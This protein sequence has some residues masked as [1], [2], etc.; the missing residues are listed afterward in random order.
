ML[1]S[2]FYLDSIFDDFMDGKENF[3]MKVDIYEKEN[4]YHIISDIPGVKKEDIKIDFSEGYLTIAF[5]KKEE[6]EESNHKKIIRK[7]RFYGKT[8][9]KFYVGNVSEE[10]IRAEFKE[11]VLTVEVPKE[12]KEKNKKVIDIM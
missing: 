7:E 6:S 8:S 2:R 10:E 1:P 5:E 9:R 4:S 3:D 11:G 12:R